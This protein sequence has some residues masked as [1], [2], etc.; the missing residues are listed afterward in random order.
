[1]NQEKNSA[2]AGCSHG[3]GEK[4]DATNEAIQLKENMSRIRHKFI[5]MSGKG[6]VG[7][8]TVA[9]N[10]AISLADRGFKTGLLDIDIHGPSIP[11]LLGI[12][13]GQIA[14]NEDEKLC[15]VEHGANLKVMSI[16]FLLSENDEAVIWRG[17]RKYGVIKQFL[18]DVAWGELDYMV[19]DSPPGT[20]DEP[21]AVCQL[22]ENPDGAIIVTTPQDVALADVRKSVTFCR[23]VNIPVTGVIENM[24]GFICPFCGSGTDIFSSGGGEKMAKDMGIRFLGR[25][26]IETMIR[27]SC[28]TGR[29]YLG[30]KSG[31]ESPAWKAFSSIAESIAIK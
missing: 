23:H 16:G 18:K 27:T 15:P 13:K 26:P 25:I 11:T 1:M 10:L 24:S 2:G 22:I 28:D 30:Q 31:E 6:G 8:S 4:S 3:S 20:G 5:V 29:P 17:P 19:I 14:V 7:K 9:V 21:L 12:R